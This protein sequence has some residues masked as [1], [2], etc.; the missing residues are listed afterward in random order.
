MRRLVC[1]LV[2]LGW[3]TGPALAEDSLISSDNPTGVELERREGSSTGSAPVDS[4][5]D[6]RQLQV[7]KKI[8]VLDAGFKTV[9]GRLVKVS[10]YALTLRTKSN[11]RKELLTFPRQDIRMVSIRHSKAKPILFLALAGALQGATASLDTGGR[12][13]FCDP[14]GD[15][16]PSGTQLAIGAGVGAV[17]MAL[18]GAFSDRSEEVV[19]SQRFSTLERFT[20]EP[21]VSP[22]HAAAAPGAFLPISRQ[23]RR[24]LRRE[25]AAG[26]VI[27][28][29]LDRPVEIP[30]TA[31]N[32]GR[33][34]LVLLRR[35]GS[36]SELYFFP[37]KRVRANRVMAV[38]PVQM[39]PQAEAEDAPH[40]AYVDEG[41]TTRIGEIGASGKVM[42][43]QPLAQT[44][45]NP[46]S[47][48][49]RYPEE[50]TRR[51]AAVVPGVARDGAGLAWV[52]AGRP[53][54]GNVFVPRGAVGGQVQHAR[55]IKQT[56]PIYPPLARQAHIQG[57]VRLEAIIA[58]DGTIQR[59]RAATGHPMLVQA[60]LDAVRRWRYQ[61][62]YLNGQPVEV[63]TT[64]D[65]H[66]TLM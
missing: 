32:P 58:K 18:T 5:E 4:W 7:W 52:G 59:L 24:Q 2:L 50:R 63:A 26:S 25:R 16:R 49:A 42:R 53:E 61:P 22:W 57:I 30:G 44:G 9:K 20:V 29:K 64:L 15:E 65:V 43:F 60:A 11:G 38:V 54:G 1:A 39:A 12:G 31:L 48:L 37:G 40:V 14:P 46:Q 8:R 47:E 45:E 27:S 62:T 23:V 13:R 56:K 10:E 21:R 19:Y 51:L 41:G 34:Q 36:A 35:H 66:F 6:L 3:L 28:I 33:Y 17:A 55:L